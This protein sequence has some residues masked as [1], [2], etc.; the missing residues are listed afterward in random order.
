[1]AYVFSLKSKSGLSFEKEEGD[2]TVDMNDFF[3]TG[4]DDDTVCSYF[5]EFDEDTGVVT[6]D[7]EWGEEDDDS[8]EGSRPDIFDIEKRLN[9]FAEFFDVE[10]ED[11]SK[12]VDDSDDYEITF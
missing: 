12:V 4:E 9:A 7:G 3:N 10:W 8:L 5:V 1:M 2:G 11:G 6:F